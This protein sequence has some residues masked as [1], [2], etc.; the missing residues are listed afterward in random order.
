MKMVKVEKAPEPKESAM[1]MPAESATASPSAIFIA[2][3]R[4]LLIGVKSVPVSIR[5]LVKEIRTVGKVTFDERKLSHIHT[6][7]AGFIEEVFVDFVGKPVKKGD[8]LFTIYSPDLVATQEEYLLALRSNTILKDSSFPWISGGSKNLVEAA[9]RRLQLWDITDD[10]IKA[11]EKDGKAKRALTIYSPVSGVVTERAAY[12]HG[13]YVT[14]EMDLYTIVDLSTVWIQGEVYESDLPLI[15]EGQTAHVEFPY[16]GGIRQRT[17]KIA[18]IAPTL[19]PATRTVKVRLEFQNSDLSLRP[20]MFV[21]FKVRIS[22]GTRTVVPEDAVL[23]TGTE[24]YVFVDKGQGY[25]EPRSV[26]VGPEAEGHYA[27]ERGVKVGERV[28]TS[29]N[30][31][32]DSES[33]LKGAFAGMGAPSHAAHGGAS[34]GQALNVEIREPKRAKVGMNMIRFMAKDAS[35]KP[36]EDAEVEVTLH[37]PQMGGMAPMTAKGKLR[38][39]GKGEYEGQVEIPMAWTWETTITATKNGKVIGTARTS[40]TAR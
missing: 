29:A 27:I 18:F 37:M 17:G 33:R 24:Q 10:E 15:A 30:F 12:H 19:D 20:D 36:I 2:P 22:L 40:I 38:S 7:V 34:G 16:S 1:A 3:E 25:F 11:L 13:R 39:I 6:K 31:I 8:P 23:D 35:G 5:P 14:P 4:Q 32:L 28:V 26:K 21:N 9:A